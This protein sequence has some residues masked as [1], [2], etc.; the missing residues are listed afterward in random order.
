MLIEKYLL[1]QSENCFCPMTIQFDKAKIY[2][3]GVIILKFDG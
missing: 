2:D 1:I 3:N